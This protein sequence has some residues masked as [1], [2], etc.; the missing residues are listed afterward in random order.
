MPE[1]GESVHEG[2]VT[3]WMKKV[4]DFVNEDE[5]VVEIMTDKVNQELQA[6][7]AGILVKIIIPEGGE[8]Q[9]FAAMGLIEPDVEAARQML[10]GG[11]A[12]ESAVTEAAADAK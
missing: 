11:G 10:A 12:P 5:P 8:V 1:L 2:T 6:P 7:A 9:V 3:R 4:G